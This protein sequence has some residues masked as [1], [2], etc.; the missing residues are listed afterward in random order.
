MSGYTKLFSTILDSTVWT[1]T[2]KEVKLLWIT[3]LLKKDRDQ[4]VRASLVGLAKCAE[5][6]IEEAETALE[7]LMSPDKNS[8]SKDH[9]GRRVLKVDDGWFIVQ[10]QKYRDLLSVEERREYNRK[11]MAEYRAAQKKKALSKGKPMDGEEKYLKE[12][13]EGGDGS[14]TLKEME[15]ADEAR[16]A[17][18]TGKEMGEKCGLSDEVAADKEM[19]GILG[20]VKDL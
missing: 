18:W 10:G 5:L 12:I 17:G 4:I 9:D 11:Y 19:D 3:M 16:I 13:E 20:K 8:H 14:K 7:F 2:P 6:T 15:A 1:N